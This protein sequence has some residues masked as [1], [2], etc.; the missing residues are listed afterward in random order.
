MEHFV[1]GRESIKFPDGNYLARS[2]NRSSIVLYSLP[3]MAI[4]K[5]AVKRSGDSFLATIEWLTRSV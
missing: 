5:T 4:S 2:I 1:T 3:G